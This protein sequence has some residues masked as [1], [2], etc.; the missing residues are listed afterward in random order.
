MVTYEE[1]LAKLKRTREFIKKTWK[2]S[3]LKGQMSEDNFKH[4]IQ[5]LKANSASKSELDEQTELYK[6]YKK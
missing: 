3:I 5:N 6:K 4:Y 2:T 1:Q